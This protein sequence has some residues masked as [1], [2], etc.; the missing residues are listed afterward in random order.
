MM[1]KLYGCICLIEDDGL[2]EKYIT[3]RD[4][5]SANIKK[6]LDSEPVSNKEF[7]KTKTKSH[8]DEVTDF[9]DKKIP[10]VN[11]NHT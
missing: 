2:L 5:V 7:L 9:Y 1:A 6:E 3:I 11:S 10:K 8:C 4:K